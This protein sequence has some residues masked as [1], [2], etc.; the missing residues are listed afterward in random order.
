[1]HLLPMQP[2]Y[3][4]ASLLTALLGLL[5]SLGSCLMVPSLLDALGPL[6]PAPCVHDPLHPLY[7]PKTDSL[8]HFSHTLI[9][10]MHLFFHLAVF[11]RIFS[12]ILHNQLGPVIP[13]SCI[14]D[15][16]NHF[17]PNELLAL[18]SILTVSSLHDSLL[19]LSPSQIVCF[20]LSHPHH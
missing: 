16:L 13:P 15:P 19:S 5:D 6:L 18:D 14:H 10:S 4:A 3:T 12:S 2:K 9:D 20:Y 11:V 17:L 7:P 8:Y 1:M